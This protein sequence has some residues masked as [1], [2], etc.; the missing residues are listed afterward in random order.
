MTSAHT[1]S[2]PDHR[3]RTGETGDKT[4]R[5]TAVKL[6]AQ[7]VNPLLRRV[8]GR[9]HL[10]FFALVY[11]RGRRSGRAYATPVSARPVAGGFM[12]P[13]TFGEGSDWISNVRSA[14]GCTIRWKGANYPVT[15]PEVVDWETARPAFGSF[16]RAFVSLMGI[17]RFVY[18]RHEP[19][20]IQETEL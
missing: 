14:G 18:L 3:S 5:R 19:L 4:R 11:H 20:N 7:R 13:L 15:A 12:V 6:A 16:E 10:P 2:P 17:E 1:Q 9:R 8:A